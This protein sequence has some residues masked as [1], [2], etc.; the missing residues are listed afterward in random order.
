MD[1]SDATRRSG[2]YHF[3][4]HS[5][6]VGGVPLTLITMRCR[7]FQCCAA[8]DWRLESRAGR[9]LNEVWSDRLSDVLCWG[10]AAWSFRTASRGVSDRALVAKRIFDSPLSLHSCGSLR[11][12]AY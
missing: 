2:R 12:T 9:S 10:L 7:Y 1:R 3:Y 8:E 11:M 4:R 6:T 5:R